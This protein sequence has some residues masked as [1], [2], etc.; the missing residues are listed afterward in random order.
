MKRF[1]LVFLALSLAALAADKP[2]ATAKEKVSGYLVDV[3]CAADYQKKG[4]AKTAAKHGKSCLTMEDCDKSGFAVLT[5]DNKIIKFDEN[6][7]K[8]ARALIKNTNKDKD[9]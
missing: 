4:D 9:W 2:S 1:A 8:E 6:G 7:N 3:S 5:D